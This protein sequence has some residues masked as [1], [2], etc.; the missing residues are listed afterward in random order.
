[1]LTDRKLR[2][3]K[4]RATLYRVADA[5][6]LCVEVTPNGSMLWRYRYRAGGAQKMIGLRASFPDTGLAAARVLR[7]EQ[8]SILR[9]GVDPSSKRKRDKVTGAIAAATTFE[10]V[11]KEW[12]ATKEKEWMPGNTLRTTNWLEQHAYPVIGATP[13][14]ELEAP[15][16]LAM[17]RKIVKRGTLETAERVRNVV[18]TVFRYAIAT[19]RAK[20][21]P[22]AD[23]RGTLPRAD[24]KNFAALVEPDDVAELLRAI[25]GYQGHPVSIAALRLA[26]L[27]FQRPGELRLSRWEEFDL[28][29]AEWRIPAVRRKL[30]KA[31]KMN[32]RTPPHIVPLSTQAVAIL[33]ELHALTG[34][35][36]FV[37]PGV[38]DARRPISENTVNAGLRRLGYT[39]E[40]MTGHG[41][42]HMAS[43]RLNEL[44][45]RADAIEEQLSHRDPNK[46]RGIYN[47]AKY[48]DE[49]RKM[50]QAW[51]DYLDGLRSGANVV[52]IRRSVKS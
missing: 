3:L 43:T 21:D 42:R 14:A 2:Q 38:R 19:G 18:S 10:A 27:V 52:P 48:L 15:E 11:A 46:V 47:Q 33:R 13:I 32:P 39:K 45:W 4:P 31:A 9:Q 51:A 17:L 1:M 28:D 5:D 26:P 25:E 29:A 20:R 30:L 36:G 50:M 49:R 35:T 24:S 40:Q 6:G 7:D 22:A 34:K 41:F 44:G 37:F 16:I 12:V 23:L 8:R